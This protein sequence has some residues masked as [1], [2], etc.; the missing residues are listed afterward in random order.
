MVYCIY[1]PLLRR[2]HFCLFLHR[3]RGDVQDPARI[4]EPWIRY[5]KAFLPNSVGFE[6][7]RQRK[8]LSHKQLNN[9]QSGATPRIATDHR[10]WSELTFKQKTSRAWNMSALNQYPSTCPTPTPTPTT[11]DT[12]TRLFYPALHCT[13]LPCRTL[14]CLVLSCPALSGPALSCPVR[15]Y[16]SCSESAAES[17]SPHSNHPFPLTGDWVHCHR[18]T[19]ALIAFPASFQNTC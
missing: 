18:R 15:S 12:L 13:A 17:S 10:F 3:N 8:N 19:L 9:G 11:T 6:Q 14:P 2:T 16:L 1:I 7:L 5:P 4:P